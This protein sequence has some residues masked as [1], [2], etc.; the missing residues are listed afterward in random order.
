VGGSW[1]V[2]GCEEVVVEGVRKGGA[3]LLLSGWHCELTWGPERSER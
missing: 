1:F 3:V 2:G